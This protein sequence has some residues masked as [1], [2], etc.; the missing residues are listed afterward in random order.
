MVAHLSMAGQG[1]PLCAFAAGVF[2]AVVSV[3]WPQP[4]ALAQTIDRSVQQ[5]SATL[6]TIVAR[7]A[8]LPGSLVE[9]GAL[10]ART[11]G[12]GKGDKAASALLARFVGLRVTRAIAAHEV[13]RRGD[14][15]MPFAVR[16]NTNI[17]LT[18]R[19]GGLG[20]ELPARALEDGVLGSRVRVLNV[21]SGKTVT[22]M[23]VGSDAVEVGR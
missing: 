15:A 13:I 8:L 18:F 7:R 22:G 20:M 1:K 12:L 3:T 16:R 4:E 11:G 19:R 9:E 2:L 14:L 21:A 10:V 17:R 6:T 23:V 5:T